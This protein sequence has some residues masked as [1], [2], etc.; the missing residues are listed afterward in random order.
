MSAPHESTGTPPTPTPEQFAE[1]AVRANR[2]TRGALAGVLGL[3]ALVTLLVPR[4][5]AFTSTGLGVTR[6]VLLISL[7]VLM[8]VA[9]GLVRRPFGIAVG[10]A[11]QVLFVLTGVML[12]AMFVVGVI[13]AA[14]WG[15]LLML[16]HELV[17]TP[18]GWRLLV[19]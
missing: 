18:G 9:A 19:S 11:L 6:T 1:R 8:I 17:G 15:R 3:E 16:R 13:F 5:I 2:A 14:I 7:A 12:V 10:S 4:A